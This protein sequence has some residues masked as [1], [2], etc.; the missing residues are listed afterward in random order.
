MATSPCCEEKMDR[1][2]IPARS[3]VA[4]VDHPYHRVTKS[5]R[6]FADALSQTHEVVE[7]DSGA[8]SGGTPI[9]A[10]EVDAVAA[11]AAVFWQTLPWPTELLKLQTPAIWVPMYDTAARKAGPLLWRVLRE[12][13]VRI[14]AFC[15]ALSRTAA[16]YGISA[17]DGTYY[18][19]PSAFGEMRRDSGGLRVFLWDR[20]EVGVRRL[21]SLLGDQEV[22]ETILRLAPDPGLRVTHPSSSDLARYRIRVI[23]GPLSR[24][25]H[26]RLLARCS[27]FVAPRELEGIGMSNLEAMAMGLAV[28]T[29]RSADDKRVHHPRGQWLPVRGSSAPGRRSWCH[30]GCGAA[31]ARADVVAGYDKWSRGAAKDA[32]DYARTISEEASVLA[33]DCSRGVRAD[34]RGASEGMDTARAKSRR[35]ERHAVL[36]ALTRNLTGAFPCCRVLCCG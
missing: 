10:R 25:E 20:G 27:V 34:R 29:Y 3:R 6:F 4:F 21:K 31:G 19:D 36:P 14:V 18:P 8:R 13:N 15:R 2:T 5:S 11:D 9:S 33:R 28:V 32:G 24:D 23:A 30:L 7:L 1:T 12:R 22:E 16:R 17:I 35:G 26:L